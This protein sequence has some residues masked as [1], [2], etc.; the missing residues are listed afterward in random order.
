MSKVLSGG[1]DIWCPK[2][3]KITTCK[4]VPTKEVNY[5]LKSGQRWYWKDHSDIRWFRRGR[6]CLVCDH[7]FLTAEATEEFVGE[8]VELRD[9]LAGIKTNTEKYVKQSNAAAKSLKKLNES[10][11]GLR[12]LKIYGKLPKDA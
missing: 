3:G 2:C 6:K 12:A 8:L 10:L 5:F 11:S 9:A 1:T 4:A 7:K